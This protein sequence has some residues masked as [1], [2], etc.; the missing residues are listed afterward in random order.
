MAGDN[1][2]EPMHSD[3][4]LGMDRRI[5]RRDF[6]DGMAVGAGALVAG[7][8][9]SGCATGSWGGIHNEVV[10]PPDGWSY[11]GHGDPAY[12]PAMTRLRGSANPAMRIPHELRDGIFWSGDKE[13]HATGE[14][15]D[16]VVVGAG[17]SGLSAAYFYR[18][19]HPGA[20]VLILDNH[21]DFG[22][23]ARRDEF[24]PGGKLIIGYGGSQSIE[25]PTVWSPV[26]KKLLADLGIE[27]KKFDKYYDQDFNKRWKL[28]D[29]EFFTADLFGTDHLA[30][31][32]G[33][34]RTAA[35]LKGAPMS[36]AAKTAYLTLQDKP[37]D[38]LPGLSDA[39]KKARLTELSY[40]KYLR[41][42]AKMPAEVLS[43][44][45]TYTNDE[46]GFGINAFGAIDAWAS[47]YPGFDGLKLDRSKPY[48]Y[49]GPTVQ[50]QWN[51]NDPYIYHFPDGN[52]GIC[53]LIIGQLIPGTGAPAAMDQEPLA[54]IDYSRLDLPGNEV[55]LRLDSPCVRAQHTGGDIGS[56]T[57]E[58]DFYRDGKVHRVSAGGVVMACYNAMI[59]YLMQDLPSVQKTGLWYGTKLPVVYA[60][61]QLRDWRAWE[62]LKIYHTRFTS[63]DWC[64]AELD[65]PVSMGG[66]AFSTDPGQPILVHMIRMATS[67][68]Y[69]N[70]R[71]GIGPGRRE[72]FARPYAEYERTIRDQLTR[73]LG[74]GG[75]DPARDIQGITVNRWGHGYALEYGRPWATF[76]PDGP[77]PSVIGRRPYGRITIANSDSQNRAYADAA[78]DAAHRA[79]TEL[80]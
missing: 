70:P 22:G 37:A 78:I 40:L 74:P 20:K 60:M 57:V 63:G 75:F 73:L 9:L 8:A 25:G 47:G 14:R 6:L 44:L 50:I 10:D 59:P 32:Q 56:K 53:K 31:M 30:V 34:T 16:L 43:Y 19:A 18:Q 65:Y 36:E 64:V 79:I 76:W 12:P 13:I 49:C 15:Y 29:S 35:T 77:L 54:K 61:V 58:V 72:L 67:P 69:D 4:E 27:L 48:R 21:D 80:R 45:Q 46:W 39:Q 2:Y 23:H 38:Y 52:H 17:I 11:A 28:N 24:H 42:V 68:A 51:E 41:D 55:R 71:G 33:D 5:S 7:G 62:R 26:A 1:S 3:R 66:Y